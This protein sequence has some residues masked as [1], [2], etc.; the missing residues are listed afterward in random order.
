MHSRSLLAAVVGLC[1]GLP[2]LSNYGFSAFIAP[3]TRQFGWSISEVSAWIFFL[4]VGSCATSLL[5]GKWVD[6]FGAGAV[7]LASIPL[8][9]AALAA[10][11]LMTG[12]IWQLRCDAFVVGAIGPG[13]SL[14][15]Y[16]Q[17]INERFAAARGTALGLMT[18][19]IGISAMLAPPLMQRITDAHGWRSAFL[20]MGA[21]SLAAY[22]FAFF[23]LR[24]TGVGRGAPQDPRRSGFTRLEA[25]RAPI[26]WL[27]GAIAF[28]VGLYSAGVIFNLL[29]FLTEVGIARPTAASYL[30]M[31]GLFMVIGKLVC[32]L[33]LDRM[34]VSLIG[35]LIL[36]AQAVALIYL[37]TYLGRHAGIV[38]AVVGF[39][40]GGQIACSSYGIARYL[41]MKSYGQVYAILSIVGSIGVGS[42]PYFFS[43]LRE[44]AVDYRLSLSVAGGLALLAAALYASLARH[45]MWG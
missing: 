21:A 14:L 2:G 20:F 33:A 29:P 28:V 37:G 38:I 23:W 19:G 8:F 35:A 39:G 12:N 45:R 22:P 40:T 26:F 42:G 34:S 41:G 24:G 13:V 1:V 44:L 11:S 27:I 36:T 7:I 9:A 5:L 4:M 3:L 43:T 18:A 15:T 10:A 6:R 17:V 16:S 25:L 30:G 32:G 31:F